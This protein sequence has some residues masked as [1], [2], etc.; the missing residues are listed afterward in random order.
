MFR[1]HSCKLE[2]EFKLKHFPKTDFCNEKLIEGFGYSQRE[3]A[4]Y[5]GMHFASIS[6]I[7]RGSCRLINC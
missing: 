6:R 7:M 5:L 1:G 3:V 4:D 2:D